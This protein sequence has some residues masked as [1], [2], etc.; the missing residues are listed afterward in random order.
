MPRVN[1]KYTFIRDSA[2]DTISM[3][4]FQGVPVR[5]YYHRVSS[6][7]YEGKVKNLIV[8]DD[9]NVELRLFGLENSKWSLKIEVVKIRKT[10]LDENNQP[11]YSEV[12]PYKK[13]DLEPIEGRLTSSLFYYNKDHRISW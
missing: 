8:A 7:Q 6:T 3:F 4:E 2:I 9:I 10:G 5:Y 13:I 1:V 12:G 11:I